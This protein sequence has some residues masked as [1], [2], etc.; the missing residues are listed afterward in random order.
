MPPKFIYKQKRENWGHEADRELKLRYKA[1]EKATATETRKRKRVEYLKWDKEIRKEQTRREKVT[2]AETRRRERDALKMSDNE[3][4][5]WNKEIQVEETRRE[6]QRDLNEEKAW[7]G[8]K[9]FGQI[10]RRFRPKFERRKPPVFNVVKT[11][12]NANA[13]F[14]TYFDTYKVYV[15]GR[16][17]PV[18]V[19]KKALA[20]TVEERRLKPGDKIRI[21]VSQPSWAKQF[22]TKLI[23]ITDDHQFFYD[24]LKAVLGYVEYKSV[25]LNE[26]V[27]EV[28]LTK[29]PRGKGR[30]TITKDNTGRKKSIITIKNTDTMCL[31]RLPN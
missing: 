26:V 20:L 19:F 2:A 23:T 4:L 12:S 27:V 15:Y 6:K 5:K 3:H 24:L 9:K 29:I 22:S 8:S 25:P 13:K 28:Q 21:I 18:A 16:V 11:Y 30:L 14:T 17:D 7:R 1:A 31:A 10:R